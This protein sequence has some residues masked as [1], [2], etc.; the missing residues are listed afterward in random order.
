[1]P[2]LAPSTPA[3]SQLS[4]FAR[5][6]ECGSPACVAS[7]SC[8][9]PGVS[10]TPQSH[11]PALPVPRALF[12]AHPLNAA[13]GRTLSSTS[14]ATY[15]HVGF[16]TVC[17]RLLLPVQTASNL[18][19]TLGLI[20]KGEWLLPQRE[21]GMT[22]GY[23]GTACATQAGH[24][25]RACQLSGAECASRPRRCH[26]RGAARRG[27]DHSAT[28]RPSRSGADLRHPAKSTSPPAFRP[29]RAPR[30]RANGMITR[31]AWPKRASKDQRPT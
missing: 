13:S 1:M 25:A 9:L 23:S 12:R 21:A 18:R 29:A 20:D 19:F 27:D 8:M 17:V 28:G 30:S 10:A 26:S 6:P 5:P 2:S 22:V 31:V 15:V 7:S 4:R 11:L 24:Q 14:V 16:L 3:R